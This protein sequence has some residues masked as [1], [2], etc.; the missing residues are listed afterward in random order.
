MVPFEGFNQSIGS[1]F[2]NSKLYNTTLS[3]QILAYWRRRWFEKYFILIIETDLFS[4]FYNQIHFFLTLSHWIYY[5]VSNDMN[6]TYKIPYQY[7]C[8][9]EIVDCRNYKKLFLNLKIICRFLVLTI[10]HMIAQ[11]LNLSRM[12]VLWNCILKSH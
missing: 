8:N 1:L 3:I 10:W 9:S 6:S 11:M 5:N 4:I 12:K 2:I 7:N